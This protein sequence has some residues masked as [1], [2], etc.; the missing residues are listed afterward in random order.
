[1]VA[2]NL[3]YLFYKTQLNLRNEAVN[4]IRIV[5][6]EETPEKPAST[7]KSCKWSFKGHESLKIKFL[8]YS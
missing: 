4:E 3:M 6:L 1:M 2:T 8:V 5:G 7:Y